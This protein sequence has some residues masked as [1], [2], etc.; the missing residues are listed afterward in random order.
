MRVG[1]EDSVAGKTGV[2][3]KAHK[4]LSLLLCTPAIVVEDAYVDSAKSQTAEMGSI[5]N[6]PE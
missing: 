3:H 2:P 6:C 1:W 5:V 4:T